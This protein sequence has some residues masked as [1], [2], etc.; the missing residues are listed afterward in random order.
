MAEIAKDNFSTE[1]MV[2]ILAISTPKDLTEASVGPTVSRR[3]FLA[4]V[5]NCSFASWIK[6][7]HVIYLSG[8]IAMSLRKS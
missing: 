4:I 7:D 3:G 2:K 1:L 8:G 6:F 5:K